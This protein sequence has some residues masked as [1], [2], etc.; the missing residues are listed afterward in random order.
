MRVGPSPP[1]PMLVACSSLV[2]ACRHERPSRSH[3]KVDQARD[4]GQR[5]R[6]RPQN[7]DPHTLFALA[8]SGGGMRA[9]A[10]SYGVLEELH[11]T[12]IVVNG[13]HRRLLDEVDLLTAVSGGSFTA[14]AYALYGEGLFKDY[15]SRFLQRDVQ[16]DI[17]SRVLNPL[18][19]PKLVGGPYGRSELAADYYDEILFEGKTF[20]DLSSLPGPFVLVTGTDLSTG[21]RLGFS[22]TEFDLLCSDVGKV[23]LSRAAATSSAVPSVFSPVTF[24]NYGSSCGYRIPDYLEDILKPAGGERPAG[25]AL[26]RFHEM[27]GLQDSR[28][29]PFIHLVDGGISDNLGLRGI[30]EAMEEIEAS[31]TLR[32]KLHRMDIQ[33]MVVLVVNARSAPS[34][35][36]DKEETPPGILGQLFQSFSVPIDR[37]SFE[38]IEL[39]KDIVARWE[40]LRELAVARR[41]LAGASEAEAEAAIPRYEL[42]AIDVS[43]D[44]IPDPDIRRHFMDLPT[45]LSLPAQEIDR[46]RA[47]GGLLLRQSSQY[48]QL[49]QSLGG[50]LP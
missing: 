29:R 28:S 41:R 26:M 35:D 32:R 15:V 43:F 18:N 2:F 1:A 4:T 21:G 50:S 8:L 46:L 7:N 22:Q 49:V 17:L 33:R 5:S 19:W 6:S 39:L 47:M 13:Q 48:R 10:F 11:R 9:A 27:E 37:Y 38:S 42:Y 20:D 36:W 30:L 23:R 40:L 45:N 31:R 25:R 14:L 24:N 3:R 16:G 12:S 44:A 34:T